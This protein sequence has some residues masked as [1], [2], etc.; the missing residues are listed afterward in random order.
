MLC[1][2][3]GSCGHPASEGWAAG[4][5]DPSA[6]ARG[7]AGH[8]ETVGQQLRFSFCDVPIRPCLFQW[9]ASGCKDEQDCCSAEEPSHPE[10]K[11]RLDVL[12]PRFLL[13]VS[14]S[15]AY[16]K[17]TFVIYALHRRTSVAEVLVVSQAVPGSA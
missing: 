16:S 1:I 13:D 6:T 15:N 17:V 14:F 3:C 7:I 5:G 2:A 11:S 4:P 12:R 8:R 9:T 10:L